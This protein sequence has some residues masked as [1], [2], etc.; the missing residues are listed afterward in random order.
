MPAEISLQGFFF[1]QSLTNQLCQ[2]KSFFGARA[3]VRLLF[4][5]LTATHVGS[6]Q[7]EQSSHAKLEGLQSWNPVD[8]SRRPQAPGGN[9]SL[10]TFFRGLKKLA[11][12]CCKK[13]SLNIYISKK[14]DLLIF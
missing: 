8:E 1:F 14:N 5:S 7:A 6:G 3:T 4:W 12:A 2:S 13:K 11:R 10:V 9:R